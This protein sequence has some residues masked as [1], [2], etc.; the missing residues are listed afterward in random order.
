M[1][2]MFGKGGTAPEIRR[3]RDSHPST[4]SVCYLAPACDAPVGTVQQYHDPEVVVLSLMLDLL[5]VSY[6]QAGVLRGDDRPS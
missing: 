2:T 5:H 6:C 3:P 4:H 1:T